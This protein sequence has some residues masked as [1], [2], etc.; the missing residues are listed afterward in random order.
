MKPFST[1]NNIPYHTR[2]AETRWDS[3]HCCTPRQFAIIIV[4]DLDSTVDFDGVPI[5][6]R[7]AFFQAVIVEYTPDDKTDMFQ[8]SILIYYCMV[9]GVSG[10]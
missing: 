2:S 1:P 10:K 4:L 5:V 6:I 7:D 9:Q 8:V 3:R